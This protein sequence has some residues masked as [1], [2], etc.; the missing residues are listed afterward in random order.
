MY[1]SKTKGHIAHA[2]LTDLDYTWRTEL[3]TR[4]MKK[5]STFLVNILFNSFYAYAHIWN[6]GNDNADSCQTTQN[7]ASDQGLNYLQ[8]TNG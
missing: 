7:M 3:E 1:L 8:G 6:I 2:V 5:N 4:A